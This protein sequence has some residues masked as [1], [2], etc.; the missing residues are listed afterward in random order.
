MLKINGA[1]YLDIMPT[2][3]VIE[4]GNKDLKMFY[5]NPFKEITDTDLKEYKGYHPRKCNGK[6]LPSYLYRFYGLDKNNEK[7]SEV[8][9]VR[10]TPTE[11][12]KL[13]NYCYN[14]KKTV[15]DVIKSFIKDLE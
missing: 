12:E 6:P 1:W 2:M 9:H 14:N 5:L 10:A 3:I 11:Q 7:S 8:L 15:S 13:E 4:L